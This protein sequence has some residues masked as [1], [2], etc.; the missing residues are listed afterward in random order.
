MKGKD[1]AVRLNK[2][3]NCNNRIITESNRH[4]TNF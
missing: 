4:L 2:L 1:T 3:T